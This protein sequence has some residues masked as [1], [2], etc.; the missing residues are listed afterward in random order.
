MPRELLWWY[1]G[2]IKFCILVVMMV[3][4]SGPIVFF[5]LLMCSDIVFRVLKVYGKLTFCYIGHISD[6]KVFFC[7]YSGSDACLI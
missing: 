6:C 3:C 2:K 5:G 1:T 4:N 7:Y